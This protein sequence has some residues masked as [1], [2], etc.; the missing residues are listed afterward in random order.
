MYY[1]EVPL[2]DQNITEVTEDESENSELQK[3]F[4]EMRKLDE[5]LSVEVCK[6]KEIR[7][8]RKELQAKLWQDFLE[9]KPAGH[10][11][12][13]DEALNTKLFLALEAH[14]GEKKHF[15]SVFETEVTDC[16]HVGDNQCLGETGKWR[17][18]FDSAQKKRL[19]ELLRQIDDEEEES[20]SRGPDS[21]D[22]VR[23]GSVLTGHGYTPGLPDLEKLI[24]IDSKIHLLLPA[25]DYHLLQSSYTNIS[26]VGWKCDGERQPGEKVLQDIKERREQELR[27]QEIQQQLEILDCSQ[28]MIN[29]PPPLTEERLRSLLDECELVESWIQDRERNETTSGDLE[30]ENHSS[31]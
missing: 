23:A 7:R 15:S 31:F 14:T 27:L 9:N 5:R 20:G 28:E 21:E 17:G 12:C 19:A 10:H 13:A 4:E 3:A 2:S 25:E 26:Q 1:T 16:E 8:Q 18:A 29:E 24:D 30:K 22:T 11:E 6:E